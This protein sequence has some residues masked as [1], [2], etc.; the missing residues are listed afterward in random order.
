MCSQSDN[1]NFSSDSLEERE[2]PKK[3]RMRKLKTFDNR[4]R[5]KTYL[6]L[7]QNRL[8]SEFMK[9]D[10]T[11]AK[12]NDTINYPTREVSNDNL[13]SSKTSLKSQEKVVKFGKSGKIPIHFWSEFTARQYKINQAVSYEKSKAQM[14]KKRLE[15]GQQMSSLNR[16]NH[17]CLKMHHQQKLSKS[18]SSLSTKTKVSEKNN[19]TTIASKKS[20]KNPSK[21]MKYVNKEAELQMKLDSMRIRHQKDRKMVEKIQNSLMPQCNSN[22]LY[23]EAVLKRIE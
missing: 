23:E 22:A 16:I 19:S 5:R 1:E 7:Y 13:Q 6:E 14:L 10:S 21:E 12:N 17:L 18:N 8:V 9:L 15:Y 3:K 4:K 2:E 20:L 11:M